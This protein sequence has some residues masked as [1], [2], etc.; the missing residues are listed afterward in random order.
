MLS[1]GAALSWL[2]DQCCSEESQTAQKM[3]T[4]VYEVMDLR[5]EESPPGANG[6]LFLPYMRGERSPI[7]DPLA[8]GVFFGLSL[9]TT[10][11]DMIRSMLEGTAYGL[12]QNLEIAKQRLGFAVKE[13]RVV[14][15]G[16][17]SRIWSQIKADALR[18]P[19]TTMDQ[20]ETAVLGAA[21]LG[22]LASGRFAD[23]REAV[24]K[25]AARPQQT[26]LP[27]PDVDSLY[28]RIYSCYLDLYAQVKD[29]FERISEIQSG[30][31]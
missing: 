17:K 22:G 7:W 14:G 23:C 25:A 24:A 5:A 13:L 4:S 15:G 2:R 31:P 20:Q 10:R 28:S 1:P 29:L 26:V 18:R 3:R 16:S 30:F 21:M 19:I 8:R 11:G 6:L 12:R 27:N 9:D